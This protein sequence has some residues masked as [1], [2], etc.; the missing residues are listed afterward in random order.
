MMLDFA[1]I[2]LIDDTVPILFLESEPIDRFTIIIF[3]IISKNLTIFLNEGHLLD[4]DF[5]F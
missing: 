3:I 1:Q 4:V 5:H 2:Q